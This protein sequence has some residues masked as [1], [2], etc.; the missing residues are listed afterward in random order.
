M[1]NIK[2]SPNHQWWLNLILYRQAGQFAVVDNQ[3]SKQPLWN[4]CPHPTTYTYSPTTILPKQIGHSSSYLS[5]R[6]Y[7][8]YFAL[9]SRP[10][11]TFTPSTP[12]K[13]YAY[14]TLNPEADSPP[15]S[16]WPAITIY[17]ARLNNSILKLASPLAR[18]FPGSSLTIV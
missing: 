16:L 13:C 14:I 10:L 15:I 18:V 8:I 17:P 12:L 7:N 6:V 5:L 11:V 1:S 9:P 4:S 3:S 2:K